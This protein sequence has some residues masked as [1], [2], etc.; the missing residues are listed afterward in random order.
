MNGLLAISSAVISD[1]IRRKV[2]WIVLLFAG[3]LA[4]VIP[5]LPSYGLGVAEAVFREVSIALMFVAAL[6]VALSLA[7]VRIPAEIERRTVYTVLARDVARWQYL[8][9]TWVGIFAVVGIVV[10][11]YTV[12]SIAIGFFAYG[13]LMPVLLQAS[14]AVWLEAGVVAAL[15]ILLSTRFG[16]VTN[17]LGALAFLFVGHSLTSLFS[18]EPGAAAPWFIPSLDL[19][20]VIDP[21]AHGTGYGPVYALSMIGGFAAWCAVL[22]LA[23]SAIFAER[24]L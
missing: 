24:D 14:L 16:V 4:M 21:V 6:A 5:S 10:L 19:F 8:T 12:I 1:A 7:T 23:G 3:L 17:V 18:A 11:V 15:A 13:T 9:A 20:N 22:L 2:V